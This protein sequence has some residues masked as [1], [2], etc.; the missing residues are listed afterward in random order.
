MEIAG[1]PPARDRT[2]PSTR[3]TLHPQPKQSIT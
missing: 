3:L 2:S 1:P